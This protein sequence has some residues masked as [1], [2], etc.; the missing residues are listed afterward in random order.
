MWVLNDRWSFI[1]SG[2][3]GIQ[4]ARKFHSAMKKMSGK[5]T[6]TIHGNADGSCV[7]KNNEEV[8]HSLYF[9]PVSY[10][11]HCLSYLIRCTWH[12]TALNSLSISR[13]FSLALITQSRKKHYRTLWGLLDLIGFVRVMSCE[14]HWFW[15]LP[16]LVTI[17]CVVYYLNVTMQNIHKISSSVLFIEFTLGRWKHLKH[18]NSKTTHWKT[19]PNQM[20]KNVIL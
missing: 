6:T 12:C 5:K 16:H 1:S 15:K 10:L 20:T 9:S 14:S 4:A 13:D 3:G 17:F 19:K 18:L 7:T 11:F 2:Y 8:K